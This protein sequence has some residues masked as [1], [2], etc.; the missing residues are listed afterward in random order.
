MW[1]NVSKRLFKLNEMRKWQQSVES[2]KDERQKRKTKIEVQR[3]LR[4][5]ERE[6]GEDQLGE[7]VKFDRVS[8]RK[9]W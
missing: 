1:G 6:R 4:E 3:K 2:V 5:G 7:E 8:E 9:S